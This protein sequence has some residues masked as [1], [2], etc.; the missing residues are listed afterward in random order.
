MGGV[1]I[2]LSALAGYIVGDLRPGSQGFQRSGV[3]LMALIV[4]CALVGF[5]DDY[6]GIRF[7]RNLGLN[8]RA[9]SAGQLLVAIAFI[10]VSIH[11][12][13]VSTKM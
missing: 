10:L 7:Q 3:A 2:V 1:A 13:G 5:I 8:K 9:K 6:L 11:W 12:V 4:G